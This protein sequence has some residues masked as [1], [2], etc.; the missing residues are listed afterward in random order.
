VRHLISVLVAPVLGAIVYVLVGIAL[1]RLSPGSLTSGSNLVALGAAVGA[2]AAYAAL[3]L[4]RLSP[5]GPM[6]LGLAFLG[7]TAWLVAEPASF[8]RTI[9]DV[10]RFGGRRIAVEPALGVTAVLG[11]P[12]LL[13]AVSPRRWRRH[14]DG[15]EPAPAYPAPAYPSPT[16]T[17]PTY[18][19]PGR[20]DPA[21]PPGASSSDVT[22]RL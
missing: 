2:G 6:L 11:V 18:S 19:S 15:V 20:S 14:A 5:L 1:T 13:T 8:E 7:L 10:F 12:L 3:L 16:Y 21:Y 4:P 9:V 17:S 22:Q